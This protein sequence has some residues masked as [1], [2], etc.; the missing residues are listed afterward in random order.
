M[1]MKTVKLGA[2]GPEVTE[3]AL[4]TLTMSPIQ[5]D[6]GREAG[7]EVVRAALDAGITF[8]DTA[9]RYS[10][11]PHVREGLSR[12]G[13]S[14]APGAPGGVVLA[15][16]SPSRTA[17]DMK[18]ELDT[19]FEELG[20]SSVD[21]YLMHLIRPG[22]DW[23][24]RDGAFRELCRARDAGRV[25]CVG[26]SSH[27]VAGLDCAMGN[28]EIEIIHACVNQKGFGVTDGTLDDLLRALGKL[29]SEGKGVYAMKPLGG[30]HLGKV[31]AEALNFVRGLDEVDAVAVGM[32]SAR[33][34][35]ANVAIFSDRPVD[36]ALAAEL[37]G[38]ERRLMINRLC[39]GC[40]ECVKRCD[41][42]ALA[43]V[44]GKSE[45]DREKCII[46][47]YCVESCPVFSIRVI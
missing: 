26:I 1:A 44:D 13:A 15:T 7:A 3:L 38:L 34:V 25:G 27:T 39:T 19:T 31:A 24:E 30:G 40:G 29:K 6:I 28:D 9:V 5:A 20:R 42:G 18:R 32:K 4:G 23:A 8:I 47:G 36:E 12:A 41:Q 16:K 17:D 2:R 22:T 11:H 35:E 46:C 43:L 10:T 45:V 14:A 21:V 33:E 37:A